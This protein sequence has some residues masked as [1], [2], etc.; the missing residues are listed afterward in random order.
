VRSCDPGGAAEE[1]R[2]RCGGSGSPSCA[3]SSAAE[4][5]AASSAELASASSPASASASA[6]AACEA[7]SAA[8][9]ASRAA[10]RASS[11]LAWQEGG[12]S[13]GCRWQLKGVGTR[14]CPPALHLG[15]HLG[16]PLHR[17]RGSAPGQRTCMRSRSVVWRATAASAAALASASSS[18]AA[19]CARPSAARSSPASRSAALA[20][21]CRDQAGVGRGELAAEQAGSAAAGCARAARSGGL[22]RCPRL[23]PC[24]HGLLPAA[25]PPTPPPALPAPREAGRALALAS[26]ADSSASVARMSASRAR[27]TAAASSSSWRFW[28]SGARLRDSR[29]CR[30]AKAG[31]DPRGEPTTVRPCPPC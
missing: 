13:R 25:L 3:C 14:P 29:S 12:H 30:P 10:A 18:A 20:A 6:T 24:T 7:A 4:A 5:V 21:S 9:P 27:S 19:L 17:Q 28:Y 31:A 8:A 22:R 16:R 15:V 26:R 23:P 11:C 1:P 2:R